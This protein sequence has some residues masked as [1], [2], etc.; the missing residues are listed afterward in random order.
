M[1]KLHILTTALVLIASSVVIFLLNVQL[2][3][4]PLLEPFANLS[5]STMSSTDF[6]D[7]ALAPSVD[8]PST[9]N[10]KN[11][12]LKIIFV[13][14][15]QFDR[16]IR[17]LA[18]KSVN[19][20]EAILDPALSSYL[21]QADLVIGNL[22]G[23]ITDNP[24][25]SLGSEVGSTRNFLFTFSP[26]VVP[27]LK[28]HNF[29]VNLGNNHI[30]NFGEDGFN[31]T[32]AYL[33]NSSIG[34]F[35]QVPY[36]PK[37]ENNSQ[38]YIYTHDNLSIAF[39]NYNQFLGPGLAAALSDIERWRPQVDKIIVYTHWGNEYEPEANAVIQN[40][41]TQLV[42]TGADL[43]IGSHPHVEQQAEDID[44]TRVYYSLGNFIFDQ[45]FSPEVQRGLL[46]E[47]T[48]DP[49]SQEF[50][51]AERTVRMSRGVTRLD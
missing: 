1:K 5:P 37:A 40:Q 20:Y 27:L 36:L 6:A 35:G 45:Y 3:P 48:I 51:F 17:A 10:L 24:S 26:S 29:A 8:A 34:W 18:Q 50:T 13:G 43:I 12:P 31:Q 33:E 15:M 16:D 49:T 28:K 39:I 4:Q 25:V 47:L 19:G 38:I 23:P 7:S 2:R 46:V 42:A 30:N 21:Q 14:D 32:R 41:A 9:A 44:G 22:E 11:V